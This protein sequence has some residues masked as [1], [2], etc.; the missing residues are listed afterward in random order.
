MLGPANGRVWAPPPPPPP[1][2]EAGELHRPW[3]SERSGTPLPLSDECQ[4]AFLPVARVIRGKQRV[5]KRERKRGGK[6]AWKT[7]AKAATVNFAGVH[8][9]ASPARRNRSGA[10]RVLKRRQW[11]SESQQPLMDCSKW[12][13]CLRNG[14]RAREE[15]TLI[16]EGKVTAC[17]DALLTEV[18][19]TVQR[20]QTWS[21]PGCYCWR[22]PQRARQSGDSPAPRRNHK[23]LRSGAETQRDHPF[24]QPIR[25]PKA[26]KKWRLINS[27]FALWSRV[28]HVFVCYNRDFVPADA[29]HC[30]PHWR[31]ASSHPAGG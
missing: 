30:A 12:E 1:A 15:H 25:R 16:Q 26:A 23:Q 29:V 18:L 21:H 13:E 7:P 9:C 4:C 11:R 27:F 10:Q 5:G 2:S 28:S 14:E 3:P 19:Q 20:T 24:T 31:A 6:T 17:G 8:H 22:Q